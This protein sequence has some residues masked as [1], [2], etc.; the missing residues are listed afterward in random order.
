M[1][2]FYLFSVYTTGL[3]YKFIDIER[4]SNHLKESQTKTKCTAIERDF[5]ALAKFYCLINTWTR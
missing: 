2:L 1:R 4:N 3:E 5:H